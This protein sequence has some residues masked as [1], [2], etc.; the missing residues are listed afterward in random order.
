MEN[1]TI[2]RIILTFKETMEELKQG[3][4][5]I[6][7]KM[8]RMMDKLSCHYTDIQL[9]KANDITFNK[10]VDALF[11]KQESAI[12]WQ[13]DFIDKMGSGNKQNL[14]IVLMIITA[15]ISIAGVF[16]GVKI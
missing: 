16:I 13:N 8:D 12:K 11:T 7:S 3:N 14:M 5:N 9:L 2:E 1:E 10:S 6:Y 15:I 4:Q